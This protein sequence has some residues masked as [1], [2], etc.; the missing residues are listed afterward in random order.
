MFQ[1]EDNDENIFLD[2]HRS[3]LAR[4]QRGG[5]SSST[6]SLWTSATT[7]IGKAYL[8]MESG[9]DQ[10]V[11]ARRPRLGDG[12]REAGQCTVA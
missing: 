7:D 9:L 1:K 8:I 12:P 11:A 2:Q 3:E 6:R 4:D 10:E 5:F